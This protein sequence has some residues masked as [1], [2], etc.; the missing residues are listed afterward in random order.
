MLALNH[1]NLLRGSGD[2]NDSATYNGTGQVVYKHND[3]NYKNTGLQASLQKQW[4]NH[5]FELGGRYTKDHYTY[6]DY[7][8]DTYNVTNAGNDTASL[9][10]D[11]STS[12]SKDSAKDRISKG[13]GNVP[14]GRDHTWTDYTRS[15]GIRYTSVEYEYN[16][17]RNDP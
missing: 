13:M 4:E 11:S 5:T 3:R 14:N 1:V 2:M 6:K 8:E 9:S 15:P 12:R 17:A 10:Y 7:T 16:G